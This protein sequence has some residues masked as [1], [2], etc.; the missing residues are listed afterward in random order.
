M[1]YEN[2]G[3]VLSTVLDGFCFL[4]Y[5]GFLLSINLRTLTIE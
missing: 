4:G 3:D 2:Q 1:L 5:F